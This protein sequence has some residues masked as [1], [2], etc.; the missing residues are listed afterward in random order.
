MHLAYSI[1]DSRLE[2]GTRRQMIVQALQMFQMQERAGE[3]VLAVEY[4][5][6][7]DVLELCSDI[8]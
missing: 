8:T 6:Y 2:Y 7:A 3:L 5:D 4:D 1:E